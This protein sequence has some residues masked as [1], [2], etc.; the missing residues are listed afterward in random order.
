[1]P[2]QIS[3]WSILTGWLWLEDGAVHAGA[4]MPASCSM[5]ADR[6]SGGFDLEKLTAGLILM[7]NPR[8]MQGSI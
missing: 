3:L 8:F 7:D 2:V 1:M 4:G 6:P 5:L